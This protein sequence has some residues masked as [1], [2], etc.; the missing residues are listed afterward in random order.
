MKTHQTLA[1]FSAIA[2]SLAM[3][4]AV[5]GPDWSNIERARAAK[6][7]EAEKSTGQ[8]NPG[9]KQVRYSSSPRAP[10]SPAPYTAASA[11][12]PTVTEALPSQATN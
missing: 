1:A 8:A 4:S 10:F 12:E 7:A 11:A 9:T 5:A 6:Q 2:F 3:G